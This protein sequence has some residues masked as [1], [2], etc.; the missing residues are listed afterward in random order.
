MN[1]KGY[2]TVKVDQTRVYTGK[3]MDAI[4]NGKAFGNNKNNIDVKRNNKISGT[5]SE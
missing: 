2:I 3:W 4:I 5:E 1:E